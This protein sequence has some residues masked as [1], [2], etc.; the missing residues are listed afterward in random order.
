MYNINEMYVYC[1]VF[2]FEHF[3]D[4]KNRVIDEK[5]CCKVN[6]EFG[7]LFNRRPF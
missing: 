4:K 2:T 1:L 3:Y 5:Q 6:S 7:S